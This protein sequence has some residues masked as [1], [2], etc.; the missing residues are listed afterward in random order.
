MLV[1][2]GWERA[3]NNNIYI[4]YHINIAYYTSYSGVVSK[5][6]VLLHALLGDSTAIA[7]SLS[8]QVGHQIKT[9][10]AFAAMT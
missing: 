10:D 7:D 3:I 1:M 2:Q 4:N 6:I 9:A 5:Q 8:P